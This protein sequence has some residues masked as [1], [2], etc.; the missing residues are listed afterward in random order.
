MLASTKEFAVIEPRAVS[1]ELGKQ[2]EASGQWSNQLLG[3]YSTMGSETLRAGGS[4]KLKTKVF[5]LSNGRY[6]N[7]SELAQAMGISASHIYRVRRGERRINE[8]F[9]AGAI[10]AFPECD[11]NSLFY[12]ASEDRRVSM[13][14]QQAGRL[15]FDDAGRKSSKD[16]H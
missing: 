13:G 11:F 15:V 5:E 3:R 12:F 4:L 8:K 16:I 7:L 9:I 10:Q 6:R 14:A 2:E 1:R